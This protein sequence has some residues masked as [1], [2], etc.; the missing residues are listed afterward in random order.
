M[1]PDPNDAAADP[2][3][4]ESRPKREISPAKLAANR[5]NAAR[6]TGPRTPDGKARRGSMDWSTAC[7]PRSTSSPA[8]TPT[9]CAERLEAWTEELG[10]E[11]EAERYLVKN[12]VRASWRIDR[13]QGAEAAALTERIQDVADWFD[14]G[15]GPRGHLLAAGFEDKTARR[16]APAPAD[17]ARLPMA[18]RAVGG[19]GASTS[20]M[21]DAVEPT[22]R[23]RGVSLMGYW[24]NDLFQEPEVERWV[25]AHVAGLSGRR[26]SS[27]RVAGLLG[28]HRPEGMSRSRSSSA[29]SG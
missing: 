29:G 2:T 25:V 1:S 5:A 24:W 17:V 23:L 26:A 6:S 11:T 4:D 20:R 22:D 9:S 28:G 21:H 27:E 3:E 15:T 10:A 12:A 14:D 19:P 18:D 7:V 8:R 13:C 16:R